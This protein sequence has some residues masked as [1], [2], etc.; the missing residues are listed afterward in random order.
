MRIYIDDRED[1]DR[2]LFLKKDQ[3]FRQMTVKRLEVGDIL[4]E[5]DDHEDIVIEIKTLQ[6]WTNSMNNKQ[7]EKEANQMKEYN[8]RGI[9]VYD[10]GKL[11]T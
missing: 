9:I 3:F 4:I 2:I 8:V 5:R 10:D 6:D 7:L 11:N 1:D